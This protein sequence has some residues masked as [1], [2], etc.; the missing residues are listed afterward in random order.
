M[1]ITCSEVLRHATRGDLRGA[2][3][4]AVDAARNQSQPVTDAIFQATRSTAESA[5]SLSEALQGTPPGLAISDYH[6]YV[7]SVYATCAL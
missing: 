5:S 1:N 6:C 3:Q 7:M 2:A 4:S